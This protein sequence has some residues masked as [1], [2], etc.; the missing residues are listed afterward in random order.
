MINI[1][2]DSTRTVGSVQFT[3]PQYSNKAFGA[4]EQQ[5]SGRKKYNVQDV[6]YFH[7][8]T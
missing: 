6:M 3:S 8:V 4:W 1:E 7:G 5:S 2:N